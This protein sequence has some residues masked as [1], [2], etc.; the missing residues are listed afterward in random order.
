MRGISGAQGE[1]SSLTLYVFSTAQWTKKW[2]PQLG[3]HSFR[4]LRL[5]V[6]DVGIEAERKQVIVLFSNLFGRTALA[7][8]LDPEEVCHP[9]WP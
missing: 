7:E 4:L 5:L 1:G 3:G 8:K 9:P 6:P 2:P